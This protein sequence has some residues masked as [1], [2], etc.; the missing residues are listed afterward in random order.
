MLLH[1]NPQTHL[2][3]HR[4]APL[5]AGH[6]TVVASDL[7]GYGESS[8]PETTADHEPYSKRAMARDQIAL[9]RHF[10]FSR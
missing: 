10:G 8:K 9:M 7:R 1:G 3:W 2:M 5:L 6:F 4:V